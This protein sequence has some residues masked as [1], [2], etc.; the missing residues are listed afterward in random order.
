MRLTRHLRNPVINSP[1]ETRS[2]G[3][4]KMSTENH[5]SKSEQ[6]VVKV[7]LDL[8]KDNGPLATESLWAEPAGDCLF[9][10]RNVP[11]FAYGFSERDI[12]K[13]EESDGKFVVTDAEERGGHSTYRIFLPT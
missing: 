13:V 6:G 7:I 12:V 2:S 4:K 10:L 5:S 8:S 3:S 9:R 1:T 11:F